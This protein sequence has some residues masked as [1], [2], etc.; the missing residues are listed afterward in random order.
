MMTQSVMTQAVNLFGNSA[1]S[2]T[3][4]GKQAGSGF[5]VLFVNSMNDRNPFAVKAPTKSE[6]EQV[7][8]S[9]MDGRGEKAE[10]ISQAAITEQAD[11]QQVNA[12]EQDTKADTLQQTSDAQADQTSEV[13]DAVQT[14][15]EAD[16]EDAIDQELLALITAMLMTISEAVMDKLDL[17]AE[18]FNQLLVDRNMT[19][20]DLL[21]PGKMQQ[22]VLTASG[23]ANILS[24]LTNEELAATMKE[25]MQQTEDILSNSDVRMTVDQI[26]EFLAK[27]ES[28]MTDAAQNIPTEAVSNPV[29]ET[30]M[31]DLPKTSETVV[32]DTAV[33]DENSTEFATATSKDNIDVSEEAKESSP[34]AQ[35]RSEGDDTKDLKA[36]DSYQAFVDN[37]VKATKETATSFSEGMTQVVDIREI[38]NQILERI[39][40]SVTPDHSF[41]ELQLNPENLG[42]VNLTVQAKNGVM[43]A[44]FTVQN[45]VTKEAIE[46]Q[47]N[48]LKETLNQQGIKV[49]E[50][51][52][53]VS[54]KG[55]DQNSNEEAQN[56]SDTQKGNSGRHIT[57]EEAMNLTELAEDEDV[58]QN[59]TGDLG[60]LVDYTA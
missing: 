30:D 27:V 6:P 54:T 22:F 43:T 3:L 16:T 5:D 7:T 34:E 46:S 14:V 20:A 9:G 19:V 44:Q 49:E 4:K 32:K 55:F 50:I 31:P 39:R 33:S 2:V 17:T 41:M 40:I 21:D 24:V 11:P 57:L 10:D 23:E 60:G 13:E 36:A 52:V 25:L 48:T 18:E 37:L 59:P 1:G 29:N 38:A 35:D 42:K 58:L 51:E 56:K 15:N 8:D 45:E 12:T 47:L 28:T 53:S 26:K